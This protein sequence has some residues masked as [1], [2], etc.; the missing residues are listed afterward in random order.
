MFDNSWKLN[1]LQTLK[2]HFEKA[3]YNNKTL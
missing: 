2:N 3:Q 1:Q